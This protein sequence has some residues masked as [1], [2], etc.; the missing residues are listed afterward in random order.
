MAAEIELFVQGVISSA[1]IEIIGLV[2]D[3]FGC[4]NGI[5]LLFIDNCDEQEKDLVTHCYLTP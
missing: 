1:I 5:R 2:I 3:I 4:S